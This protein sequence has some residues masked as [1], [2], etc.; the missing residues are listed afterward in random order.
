MIFAKSDMAG[1]A[2]HQHGTHHYHFRWLALS[3]DHLRVGLKASCREVDR[4][5]HKHVIAEAIL[6]RLYQ[7]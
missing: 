3:V 6:I 2:R 4:E 1:L 5:A 7:R